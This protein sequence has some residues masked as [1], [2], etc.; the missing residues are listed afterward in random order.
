MNG[1]KD[2]N[3]ITEINEEKDQT[4]AHRSRRKSRG[5]KRSEKSAEAYAAATKGGEAAID[6]KKAKR[7]KIILIAVCA[8]LAIALAGIIYVA[9]VIISAPD[10]KT[11]NI[12]SMLS[13]STVLYDDEGEIIDTAYGDQNRTIVEISSIPEHVQNAFIALEDKTFRTHSGFN[14]VRIFGAVKDAVFSG[15]QISGT[16]TITQQLARNLYLGDEMSERSLSRKIKEAYYAVILEQK[17]SKDQILEAY[18]NTI[19][20]GCGSGIQTACQA[21]FSKDVQDV[22]VAEAAALA[23]LPQAPSKFA[24]VVIASADEISDDDPKLIM[25]SGEYAYLWN[26][27]CKDRMATCLSLMLEQGY[28]SEEEYEEASAMEIKDIVNPNPDAL[29]TGSNYFADYVLETVISDFVESG[30]YTEE[31]A[32]D[33]VYNGGL[34]INTTMDSQAQSVIEDEFQNTA[35]FP[36][37][38]GYSTDG[39]GNILGEGGNV[40]LY[41][42]SNYI[43]D[44]GYFTLRSDEYKKNDDGSLTVYAGK[45]LNIYDTVLPDGSA[46]YS[47]EFKNMYVRENGTIYSIAGGYINIPQNYK[48]K[49]SDGN[50]V[51]SAQFFEDYPEFFKESG[52]GLYTDQFTL[53]QRV[54]QPQAAMT[55]VDNSTGQIK[56][57]VGGRNTSGRRLFNRATT[58]QQPGSSLKPIA[59][60]S[61]ALQRSYELQQAGKKFS[62]VDNGFDK[63]GAE[64]W[65]NYLTAASIVDD[66][67]TTINGKVWPKNS[68][69]SYRGLYTFRQAL[70]QSVNVCAVKI[71]SQVGVDYS[72]D[73]VE[74][75]GITTLVRDGSTNDL[76]LSAL[77]MG[78]M[79]NGTSTLEMASAYTTFVNDGVHK[80][81]S[82]YTTVTTRSGDVLLEAETEET[83]VLNSGVAWIMRDILRTVVTE[84]IASPAAISGVQVG[85]KTGTTD[86]MYDIW[87]CGFTP[88]Y[89]AALWIGND[90]NI[91]L[92]SDSY[93]AS[94]LW[95]RIMSQIDGAKTGSYSSRPDNVVS[96]KIDT[97]SGM[98]ASEESGRSVRTEYF[99]SGTAPTEHDNVHQTIEVCADT[100]YRAT[101]SCPDTEERS[102][103]MRPYVPNDKVGDIKSELPHYYCNVHNPDPDSYPTEPGKKVTIVKEPATKPD[104]EDK[105]VV[106]PPEEDSGD[107]SDEDPDETPQTPDEPSDPSDGEQGGENTGGTKSDR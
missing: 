89:S 65:G 86:D 106:A 93:M 80:S 6:P 7:R 42:Y 66:E 26:D 79:A 87:F 76:N 88:S 103:V 45:R 16:S 8:A 90:V 29:S 75:F 96:A 55:I 47:V 20:F 53:N 28:I 77:G 98:L 71:L 74:D 99:T 10:I 57:M 37:P 102:G 95:S 9:A 21:Y 54:I 82:C 59:V 72:A 33:L 85:G 48:S 101:P 49:D 30:D 94:R 31:E 40:L 1:F 11:D 43:S 61:A 23:S 64:L 63:Q 91:S 18:L 15:G 56:A 41:H 44:D 32:T 27:A 84:G 105:P 36:A 46:D 5:K 38:T 17:L 58:T 51:V 13:Q 97:K 83:E 34:K 25:K 104:E 14:I 73:I 4:S 50:L 22:T 24:L 100:G 67:P 52:S 62:F 2:H 3:D 68:Y 19:A 78:G 69:R 12:Y 70:Q 35:N 39:A 60:Y 107:D 92:T 81:Y